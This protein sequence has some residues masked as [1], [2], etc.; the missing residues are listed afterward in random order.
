MV[1]KNAT[2]GVGMPHF[3]SSRLL[4]LT[5]I[6]QIGARHFGFGILFLMVNS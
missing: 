2:F 5:S 4:N 1:T 3:E 6:V